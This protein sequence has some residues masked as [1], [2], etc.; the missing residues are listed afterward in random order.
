M[1]FH[2]E[3]RGRAIEIHTFCIADLDVSFRTMLGSVMLFAKTA[4]FK[5]PMKLDSKKSSNKEL[6][7]KCSFLS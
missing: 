3:L 1:N 5:I 7:E 6:C 4:Y 2:Y